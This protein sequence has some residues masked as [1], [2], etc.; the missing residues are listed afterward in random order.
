MEYK[1]LEELT[2]KELKELESV[3]LEE[4]KRKEFMGEIEKI[5]NRKIEIA[6]IY[7]KNS[8]NPIFNSNSV[9]NYDSRLENKC[10]KVLENILVNELP[11]FLGSMRSPRNTMFSDFY[12]IE[13]HYESQA[14]VNDDLRLLLQIS[15][16]LYFY[17][18]DKEIILP[19]ETLRLK[20]VDDIFKNNPTLQ[21]E[22]IGPYNMLN[23]IKDY[24]Y[25]LLKQNPNID[26]EDVFKDYS[27]KKELVNLRLRDISSY[28]LE[29]RN[30]TN[31][32]LCICNLS[33]S[34]NA[35]KVSKYNTADQ[36]LFIDTLAFGTTLEKI[37]NRN[38]EDYQ[39][40]F[41]LPQ[42]KKLMK[43]VKKTT[44]Q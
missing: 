44:N 12:H 43:K 13:K 23:Y 29:I 33:L 7:E 11:F 22:L 36:D 20:K 37:E 30:G 4:N 18:R 32:K 40:L 16:Y 8:V 3:L 31:L 28:L 38:Y 24:I 26:R 27:E 35:E 14:K 6:R 39:K 17:Y 15:S 9:P 42:G 5:K 34:K 2:Y 25:S 41:Y 10:S 1:F 21:G 19:S